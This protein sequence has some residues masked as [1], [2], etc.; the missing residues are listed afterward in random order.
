MCTN[1]VQN[2][3][4]PVTTLPLLYEHMDQFSADQLVCRLASP[5]LNAQVGSNNELM[6]IRDALQKRYGIDLSDVESLDERQRYDDD[7]Q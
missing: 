2:G 7:E 5:Y 4:T 3:A 6:A 1:A